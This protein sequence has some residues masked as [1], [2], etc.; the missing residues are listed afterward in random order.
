MANFYAAD[1]EFGLPI[2]D[3]LFDGVFRLSIQ[4]IYIK[5]RFVSPC[6][7]YTPVFHSISILNYI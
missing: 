2:M 5:Y 3:D 4:Q 1:T 6:V 7:Q